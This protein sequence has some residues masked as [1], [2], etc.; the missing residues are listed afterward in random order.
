MTNPT[1]TPSIEAAALEPC[2]LCHKTDQLENA[3]ARELDAARPKPAHTDVAAKLAEALRDLYNDTGSRNWQ[4]AEKARLALAYYDAAQ[5]QREGE[6]QPPSDID[7][8]RGRY[9][10]KVTQHWLRVAF[11][12]IAAG[13]PEV[14]VLDD[15]GYTSQHAPA[16]QQAPILAQ[17]EGE[18]LVC[19]I[20]GDSALFWVADWDSGFGAYRTRDPAFQQAPSEAQH[21]GVPV[22]A[23]MV[24]D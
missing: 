12:R 13:E 24:K 23:Q 9:P 4:V 3:R 10:G 7:W 8:E 1:S 20:H 18:V 6:M 2:P 19:S 14:E 21:S 5:A 11:E 22:D 17:R 16:E 15:Y